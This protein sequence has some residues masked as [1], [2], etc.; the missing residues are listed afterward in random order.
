VSE[1]GDNTGTGQGCCVR[2]RLVATTDLHAH[3][4]PW[5]YYTDQP[6]DGYGLVRLATMLRA[7]RAEADNSIYVDNG[8]LIEG[9]PL[10]EH[11]VHRAAT[12]Q[13]RMHPMIAALNAL[14][15]DAAS[16]GNHEFS[17]GLPYLQ[18]TLRDANY[19]VVC[20]NILRRDTDAGAA[21]G[22]AALFRPWVILN[23]KVVDTADPGGGG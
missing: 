6:L 20:A 10:A 1:G 11:A 2:L 12:G 22:E 8:D 4:M 16:L 14:G 13:A 3:L 15:C 18:S 21:A 5:D 17:Y 7:A 9:S 19:P 23:R